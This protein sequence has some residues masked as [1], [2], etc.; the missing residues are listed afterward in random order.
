MYSQF[1]TSVGVP[2]DWC[3]TDV[4]GLDSEL[5]S[6]IPQ[7][8]LALLLLFPITEKFEAYFEEQKKARMEQEVSSQVYFMKQ[9]VGNACGTIALIHSIAN[10]LDSI[11]LSEGHLKTFLEATK[12]MDPDERATKLEE[13]H[14]LSN[15]HEE[16]A[17]E[18]QTEAPDRDEK[19][20]LH[21]IALVAK[22]GS[23]YELDGRQE[24]P[25]NHGPTTPDSFL[26][27]F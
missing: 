13:D 7:P 22:D 3:M 21:F 16:S 19:V 10:N 18:G 23:L 12:N 9:T 8:A 25:T 5:L 6:I 27:V 20:D 1:L 24:R 14:S 2:E 4:Y 26:E 11:N 17:A 15:A